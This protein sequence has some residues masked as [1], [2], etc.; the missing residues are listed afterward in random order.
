MIRNMIRFY[1]EDLLGPCTN[2]KLGDHPLS[3]VCNCLFS[4]FAATVHIGSR[5]STRIR[6]T[7]RAV[8]TGT[9]LSRPYITVII[10]IIII[11]NITFQNFVS[12]TVL[13]RCCLSRTV[14][15]LSHLAHICSTKIPAV[16]YLGKIY[17]VLCFKV[18]N[19]II[20]Q[21]LFR[22]LCRLAGLLFR[23]GG[24]L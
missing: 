8:V 10:I 7:L 21:I 4:I 3:A 16:N 1:G 22:L 15:Y 6:R 18:P 12:V 14:H 9:H 20:G 13:L 23:A 19:L 11:I 24:D 17:W 5:P 2:P